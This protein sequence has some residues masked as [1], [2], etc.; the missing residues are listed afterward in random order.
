[1]NDKKIQAIIRKFEYFRYK[2]E[3]LS[4][5]QDA[6]AMWSFA[7]SNKF[8][9]PAAERREK[10]YLEIAKRYSSEELKILSDIFVDVF[11]LLSNCTTDGVFDDYL[12]ELYMAMEI[13]SKRT[14]QFFTPYNVSRMMAE[15]TVTDRPLPDKE[16]IVMNEPTCGA[17]G[18]ILATA[19]VL[20]NKYK[21]NY[22]DRLLVIAQD[23][24]IRCVFMTYLQT[25]LAGIPAIIYHCNTLTLQTWDV[26]YTP[27]YLFQ[28]PKFQRALKNDNG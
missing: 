11:I 1:M 17:G 27:A 2:R 14:G 12:G 26:F 24:D 15:I 13:G 16:V 28:W 10:Q 21:F 7:L 22:A 19:D 25:A 18:M 5:F 3:M 8:D 9:K 20:W 23:I 6:L 4:V